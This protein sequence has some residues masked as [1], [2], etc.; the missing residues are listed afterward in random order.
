MVPI[1]RPGVTER[2][3][4]QPNVHA[5][6]PG[7]KPNRQRSSVMGAV[8][9]VIS[10]CPNRTLA[11]CGETKLAVHAMLVTRT[12]K[13]MAS[14]PSARAQ[15]SR[16]GVRVLRRWGVMTSGALSVDVMP[17]YAV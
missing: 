3:E 10:P 8:A 4:G 5:R 17:S 6:V 11:P 2:Y 16:V 14:G 12:T 7:L 13:T 1:T 9:M 15:V